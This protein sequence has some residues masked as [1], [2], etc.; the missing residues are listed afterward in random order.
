MFKKVFLISSIFIVLS[1]TKSYAALP[2]EEIK[3]PPG[4]KIEVFAEGVAGAR[5]MALGNNGTLYIG[6]RDQGVVY[7]VRDLDGDHEADEI[8]VIAEGLNMPNGVAFLNGDLYVSEISRILK[9]NQIENYPDKPPE[10]QVIND[11]FPQDKHHG[12]KYIA[13]GPDGMLYIP[14]G[15]PCNKCEPPSDIYST[16]T[17]MD[18]DGKGLEIFA[19]GIRNTVGFDWHPETGKLWF[20]ENGSDWMGDN[21]PPDELN[22][23]D[24]KGEHFGYPYIHGYA[25][26]DPEYGEGHDP[27]NY[28][29]PMIEL[30][31]HVAALGMCFY[32]GT[33]FPPEY[34]N[35][36]FIAEHGSW[37]RTEPI[38]YRIMH[39]EVEENEA[40]SYNVFAEGWL[41][42]DTA[43]G[44]PVDVLVMPDGAL[45]V[46]DDKSGTIYRISY[47]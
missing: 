42:K 26:V 28:T 27:G 10:P 36:I 19:Y 25:M 5:S 15:A 16:I 32:T 7:A 46:S 12:W 4:F 33:M 47:Q 3:L 29:P 45:L 23:V 22:R 35:D 20:T 17:R 6:T 43:W 9:F 11:D 30:G 21:R 8:K 14:V 40:V 1:I 34:R 37:N 44:R 2:I 41:Q 13:F 24:K 31:P 38:G 39:V 18:P